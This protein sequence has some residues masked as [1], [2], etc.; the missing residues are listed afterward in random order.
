M[1]LFQDCISTHQSS[2]L[3]CYCFFFSFNQGIASTEQLVGASEVTE[4]E[5]TLCLTTRQPIAAW[6]RT[7]QK[8]VITH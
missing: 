4:V 7:P 1:A 5:R 2:L 8:S 6:K 3:C